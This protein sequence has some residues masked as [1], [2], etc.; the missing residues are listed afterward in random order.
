MYSILCARKKTEM[1]SRHHTIAV[2]DRKEGGYPYL[3]N[4]ASRSC[5]CRSMSSLLQKAKRT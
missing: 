4:F 5:T 3:R 1:L 2:R